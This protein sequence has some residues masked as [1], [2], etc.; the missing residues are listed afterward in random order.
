MSTRH[1]LTST[2]LLVLTAACQRSGEAGDDSTTEPTTSSTTA[3]STTEPAST[4]TTTDTTTTTSTAGTTTT[5][6]TLEPPACG[7]HHQDPGE[8]CDEGPNNSDNGTCK[9]DC[10]LAAC[11]DGLLQPGELCDDGNLDDTDACT[12]VCAPAAC[13]DGF[14]QNG[15]AC[16]DGNLEDLDAC[17]ALCKHN[18]CGDGLLN[19]GIEA[20]D[21]AGPSATCDLD[22]SEPVC[23][24]GLQN[25]DAGELC[26]D[27]NLANTDLC[28]AVCEPSACGDGFLQW[29]E[30]CDD[31]NLEAGDG[32]DLACKKE[33]ITCQNQA[34]KISVAPGNRAVLCTRQ[35][36]CEQDFLLLCPKDWHLCSATEFN[37]RNTDWDFSPTKLVLGGVRCRDGGGAGHYGFKS[38]MSVDHGD[39]CIYS[40][41]RPECYSPLGCDDKN[42]FALCCAPLAT[43]GNGVVDHPEEQCDD[44]NKNETD[45][46]FAHCMLTS[47]PEAQGCG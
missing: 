10:T 39:N 23:G 34:T 15:E 41:S 24:D 6:T 14:K 43:C 7:D 21:D 30:L 26:D 8:Q 40:S 18:T 27:G 25:T 42:N 31:G 32:C 2:L 37:A 3:T 1:R 20:C 5:S 22:C 11:G 13:G 45:G 17:T 38:T 29:G 9:L 44:G 46:C 4:S 28:T 47:A 16:D 19:T 35:D 36:V 12:S 33:V